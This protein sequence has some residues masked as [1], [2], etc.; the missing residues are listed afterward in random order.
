MDEDLYDDGYQSNNGY[1]NRW[2]VMPMNGEY[3]TSEFKI[4]LRN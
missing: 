3:P 2:Y 1:G 4:T